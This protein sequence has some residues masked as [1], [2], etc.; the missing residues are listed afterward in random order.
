MF[1]LLFLTY[2]G[3]KDVHFVSFYHTKICIGFVLVPR[4][5]SNNLGLCL[6]LIIVT[7]LDSRRIFFIWKIK[8]YEAWDLGLE[9]TMSILEC[10]NKFSHCMQLLSL[11]FVCVVAL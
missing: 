4:A 2:H 11:T 5:Y 9:C 1:I 7:C 3:Q 8:K 6:D 10:T